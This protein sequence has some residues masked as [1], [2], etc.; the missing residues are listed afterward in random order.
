MIL[1]IKHL[2]PEE[3]LPC[4]NKTSPAE[5]EKKDPEMSL[6][7]RIGQALGTP[8]FMV[9][10]YSPMQSELS[11]DRSNH[12]AEMILGKVTPAMM[13]TASIGLSIKASEFSKNGATQFA[14]G[15]LSGE[16]KVELE[17]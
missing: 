13:M 15:M 8:H 16:I 10:R 7:D 14:L 12:E 17:K 6:K 4:A 1:Q 3:E 5:E 2:G 11:R 9:V